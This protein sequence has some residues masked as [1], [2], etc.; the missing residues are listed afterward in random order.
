[1]KCS[2]K[3]TGESVR[4]RGPPVQGPC[5]R[6]SV[7][8]CGVHSRSIWRRVLSVSIGKSEPSMSVRAP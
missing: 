7:S 4:P 5:P 2:R 3:G 6:L 8:E 1:M